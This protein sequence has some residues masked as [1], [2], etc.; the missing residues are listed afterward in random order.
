MKT[1]RQVREILNTIDKDITDRIREQYE[2]YKEKL[3]QLDGETDRSRNAPG[4]KPVIL[5]SEMERE[6]LTAKIHALQQ[7]TNKLGYD[8]KRDVDDG[9]H[10]IRLHR[11]GVVRH[12]VTE[13]L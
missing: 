5:W 1:E 2:E 7:L 10:R 9:I 3:R 13:G 6:E 12:K 8:W 11:I 4:F